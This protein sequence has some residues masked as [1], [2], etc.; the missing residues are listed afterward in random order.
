LLVDDEQ[1]ITVSASGMTR[2]KTLRIVEGMQPVGKQQ[3]SCICI[4]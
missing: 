1:T 4:R 2:E 3:K